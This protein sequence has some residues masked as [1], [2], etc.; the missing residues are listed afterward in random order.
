MLI[1]VGVSG[2][3]P[4][5]TTLIMWKGGGIHFCRWLRGLQKGRICPLLEFSA[6]PAQ[7]RERNFFPVFSQRA[8]AA[9]P[10]SHRAG[11]VTQDLGYQDVIK[12]MNYSLSQAL[13]VA[14][15]ECWLYRH[16]YKLL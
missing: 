14:S 9:H 10:L 6:G 13:F 4:A 1:K 8:C 3:Y 5:T 2:Q 15:G 16:L 7:S 11:K 12:S